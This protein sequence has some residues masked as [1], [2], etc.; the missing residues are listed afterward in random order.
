MEKNPPGWVSWPQA[1]AALKAN[2]PT[3]LALLILKTGGRQVVITSL[4]MASMI[5]QDINLCVRFNDATGIELSLVDTEQTK[6]ILSSEGATK[7]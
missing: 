7:H 3:I 1:V 2:W 5:T 6:A 4:D